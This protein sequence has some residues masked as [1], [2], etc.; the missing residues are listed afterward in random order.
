MMIE[1][2]L[3]QTGEVTA[4]TDEANRQFVVKYFPACFVEVTVL[5]PKSEIVRQMRVCVYQLTTDVPA[6]AALAPLKI[7][8]NHHCWCETTMSGTSNVLFGKSL[9]A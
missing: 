7:F 1:T 4:H 9:A 2:E 3:N 5:I 6:R 8:R